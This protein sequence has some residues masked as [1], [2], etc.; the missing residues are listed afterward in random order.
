MI[1]KCQ[2]LVSSLLLNISKAKKTFPRVLKPMAQPTRSGQRTSA[3]E[4]VDRH[5]STLCLFLLGVS[6][7]FINVEE[8]SFQK[9][10]VS[11]K[12]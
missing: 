7:V 5:C 9:R 1:I 12:S 3:E 2:V 8:Y 4:R 6:A 11:I 10:V